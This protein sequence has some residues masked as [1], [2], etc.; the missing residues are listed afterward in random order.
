VALAEGSCPFIH[1]SP[2]RRLGYPSNHLFPIERVCPPT[3]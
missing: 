3:T 2:A 1:S